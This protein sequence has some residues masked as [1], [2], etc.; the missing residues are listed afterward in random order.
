M[1]IDSE[2]CR[3]LPLELENRGRKDLLSSGSPARL[4][5]VASPHTLL[6]MGRDETSHQTYVRSAAA[7]KVQLRLFTED[8]D[9]VALCRDYWEADEEGQYRYSVKALG[10]QYDIS[11]GRVSQAV[12]AVSEARSSGVS[13]ETCG[14]GFIV[15]SRQ[16]LGDLQRP[17]GRHSSECAACREAR[18]LARIEAQKQLESDRKLH[19]EDA[20]ALRSDDPIELDELGLAEGLS[21]LALIRSLEHFSTDAILPLS[22][23]EEPFAPTVDFGIEQVK[24]LFNLGLIR[25]HP[26]SD[27]GAFVWDNDE[28][29]RFYLDRAAWVVRGQGSP[30]G[31]TLELERRLATA[32]REDDWPDVW[33]NEWQDLWV[34]IGIEEA[35]AHIQFCLAE[36]DFPFAAGSKTRGT[37]MDLLETFSIGQIYN[38]NWRAA[39]DA[40]AYWMRSE[41]TKHQAA[42][43]CV[44][45]I[46]RQA[47][48]ARA[49]GWDVK[50][51]SR[52]WQLPLSSVSH[53]FFTV[54]M[55]ES[56]M[57]TARLSGR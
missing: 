5:S 53:I 28:V 24:N 43:S 13:C 26:R 57:M 54:V 34:Q 38:F 17:S 30:E 22:K 15:R 37:Y 20:F 9:K 36:H 44:G 41:I 35:I 33:H 25:I 14:E 52:L 42:N 8:P 51:F 16:Q 23:R 45:N 55:K 12:A 46:Q 48:R 7:G 31:R 29:D 21:L 6:S 32:Y 2:P 10:A 4:G 39:K 50:P 56:D 3:K 11:P 40:A 18:E 49:S 19:L 1:S 47:D 27:L